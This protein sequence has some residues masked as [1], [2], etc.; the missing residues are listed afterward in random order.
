[1]SIDPRKDIVQI[2]HGDE[3]QDNIDFK[4]DGEDENDEAAFANSDIDPDF[5]YLKYHLQDGKSQREWRLQHSSNNDKI[6]IYKRNN[7]KSWSNIALKC[8]AELEHIPKHII[9]KAITDMNLRAKWDK[10][11]GPIEV[12][13]HDKRN[14][15][16]YVRTSMI[17][18]FHL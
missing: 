17:V 6:K 12:L 11:M 9:M 2:A 5:A 15:L 3:N 7:N 10:S 4:S 16:C 1:M 13:E 14:D 8:V 18:P